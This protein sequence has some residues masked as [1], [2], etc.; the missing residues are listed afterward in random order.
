MITS[1]KNVRDKLK[2]LKQ[3]TL[4]ELNDT[5]ITI[6][7]PCILSERKVNA[8]D[9]YLLIDMGYSQSQVAKQL[10]IS[11]QV[12]HWLENERKTMFNS[13]DKQQG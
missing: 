9:V 10:E 12:V 8:K 11:R 1:V 13:I 4:I 6:V 3:D 2:G 5:G 7:R